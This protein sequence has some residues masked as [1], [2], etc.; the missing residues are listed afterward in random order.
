MN[1]TVQGEN[2]TT[3]RGT[4]RVRR[5]LYSI[6]PVNVTIATIVNVSCCQVDLQHIMYMTDEDYKQLLR[7]QMSVYKNSMS[8]FLFNISTY[9]LC[10][11]T[12]EISNRSDWAD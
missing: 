12:S 4:G 2:M 5:I 9:L 3:W 11:N 6:G 8:N 7:T 1:F 10:H